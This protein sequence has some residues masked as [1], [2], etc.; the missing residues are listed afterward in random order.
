M[1]MKCRSAPFSALSLEEFASI[2]IEQKRSK[3]NKPIL[4]KLAL[5]KIDHIIINDDGDMAT[6]RTMS[7]KR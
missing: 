5:L 1:M 4:L 2:K 3:S 7:P 6:A